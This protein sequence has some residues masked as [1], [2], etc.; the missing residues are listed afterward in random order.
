MRGINLL[1]SAKELFEKEAL[2]LP[3]LYVDPEVFELEKERIF[4]RSW[5]FLAHE[6]EIPRPGDYVMRYICE[7]SFLVCRTENGEISVLYNMCR[8]RGTQLCR[9]ERG[10]TVAFRCPYHG[11][12]FKNTG[13]LIGVP[14]ESEVFGGINK[15]EWSLYSPRV[16]T[17]YGMI[18]VNLDPEA[19]S[20]KEFLAG[21]EW[22]LAFYLEGGMEV[23]GPPHRWIVPANWKVGAE[24]FIGDDY[25]VGFLHRS[26]L[27]V[28]IIPAPYDF[29]KHGVM[30][31]CGPWGGF[32]IGGGFPSLVHYPSELHE[33][34]KRKL[35]P[36]QV[37]VIEKQLLLG[38]STLFPN[39]SFLVP[40]APYLTIRVWRPLGAE[41][42]EI[43]SWCLV[44]REAPEEF[45][46]SAYRAY[47]LQFGTSG[48]VEQDDT[49]AWSS[50]TRACKGIVANRIPLNSRM[51]L[52][53]WE[54]SADWPGPGTAYPFGYIEANQR[55]FW[56][57]YFQYMLG[58]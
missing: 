1:E 22:Y 38:N 8:H 32:L 20:L 27:E 18:F 16:E 37:A 25:H 13:E 12:T 51:G 2:L 26:A 11:W 35:Q 15:R 9:A 6:S 7:D 3:G 48:T 34:I 43:W 5:V 42:M 52:D 47:V 56:R 50:I 39:L 19:P 14:Y 29:L 55:S 28:Q 58:T 23:C 4:A 45:K 21:A 36:G 10:N 41:R 46:Q 44:A 17:L 30:V 33:E 53:C 40:G 49:E 24:N 57:L 31:H 54:P